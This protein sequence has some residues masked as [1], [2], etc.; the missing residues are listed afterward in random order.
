MSEHAACLVRRFID[1][2]WNEGKTHEIPEFIHGAYAAD[3]APFG[4]DDVVQNVRAYRRAFPDLIVTIETLVAERGSVAGLLRFQGTHRDVWKGLQPTGRRV[5]YR[6][7]AFWTIEGGKIASGT[8]LA[9][10]LGLRI[11]L[12]QIPREIWLGRAMA[13][14][15]AHIRHEEA[16]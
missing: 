4:I 13:V 12:G 14:G 2:V 3:G 7:A 15:A 16:T 1:R 9:D 5:D 10:A 11:Q 6:E 8:F